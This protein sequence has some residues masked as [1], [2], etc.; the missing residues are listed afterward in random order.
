M[1]RACRSNLAALAKGL[2]FVSPWIIGFCAF[3]LIPVALSLYYSFCDFTLLQPPLFTGLENYR[4]LWSDPVFWQVL[5]N[6][7]RYGVMALPAAMMV[8]IGLALM[9]NANVRGQGVYRTIVFLPSLVPIIA[10]SMLWL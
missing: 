3:K 2:A 1:N 7:L 8:S 4:T 10:S 5:S 9:L 6:T